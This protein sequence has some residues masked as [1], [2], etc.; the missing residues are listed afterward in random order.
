MENQAQR[1]ICRAELLARQE[2]VNNWR[3][4]DGGLTWAAS[5]ELSDIQVALK[6]LDMNDRQAT[7]QWLGEDWADMFDWS[8]PFRILAEWAFI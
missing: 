5:D 4:N 7:R 1:D 6:H 2:E 3:A 8:E